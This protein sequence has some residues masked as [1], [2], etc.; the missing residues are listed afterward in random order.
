MKV[1][2]ATENAHKLS[3][4]RAILAPLV[5]S[6]ELI[7]L[8]DIQCAIALPEETGET[9]EANA[10]LKAIH[11]AKATGLPS[12]GDDSGLCVDALDGAPGIYSRR[13][14]GDD[15]TDADRIAKLL[16][17]L[18]RKHALTPE[19][20]GA[21][22]V[23]VVTFATPD[24]GTQ[25]FMGEC[26]GVIFEEPRGANGFGYDP[27][28]FLPEHGRTMAELSY[29]E[30]NVVSHRARSIRLFAASRRIEPCFPFMSP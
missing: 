10:M 18:S 4:M 13:W 6:L 25:S 7:A 26:R 21:Q 15:A 30:K 19:Q 29:A 17:E 12:I 28:F 23:S 24:G 5:P 2:L 14:A 11:V 3:E 8:Q 20:R 16:N 22:F 1:V 27:V 9:F